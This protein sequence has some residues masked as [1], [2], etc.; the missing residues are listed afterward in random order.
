MSTGIHQSLQNIHLTFSQ[1]YNNNNRIIQSDRHKISL[2]LLGNY[3][4][5]DCTKFTE[6]IECYH[7][8]I[9]VH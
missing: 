9:L 1:Q 7:V 3:F 4:I 8:N 5:G 2:Y 6:L